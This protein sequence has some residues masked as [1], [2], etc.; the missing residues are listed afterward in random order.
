MTTVDIPRPRLSLVPGDVVESW[1]DPSL[2]LDAHN[3]DTQRAGRRFM[4][5]IFHE[6]LVEHRLKELL[7]VKIA[8]WRNCDY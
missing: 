4:W 5:F 1:N 7:R 2:S 6:G 3:R 8:S